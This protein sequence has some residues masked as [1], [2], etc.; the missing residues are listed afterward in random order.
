MGARLL[1]LGLAALAYVKLGQPDNA[2]RL[3]DRAVP[4]CEALRATYGWT[5]MW[6]EMALAE[7]E[8]S[9][10]RPPAAR[11]VARQAVESARGSHFRMEL[12]AALRVLAQGLAASGN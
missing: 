8:L 2:R 7:L 9:L 12:G 4:E 3:L 6:L 1:G 11:A 5:M 10:G